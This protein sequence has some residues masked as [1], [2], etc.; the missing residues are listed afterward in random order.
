MNVSGA[1]Q[2]SLGLVS[3][4]LGLAALAYMLFVPNLSDST[5]AIGASGHHIQTIRYISL[6]QEGLGP[7][8]GALAFVIGALLIA[9]PVSS[10]LFVS[11]SKRRWGLVLLIVTGLLLVAA[12]LDT[13]GAL[14]WW[15]P[16]PLA[17]TPLTLSRAA[18]QLSRNPF[19]LLLLPSIVLAW[20]ATTGALRNR[21]ENA[22]PT[23]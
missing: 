8:Y 13:L 12:V 5:D 19:G 17:G 11:T 6:Y 14:T 18:S 23:V 20:F 3:S 4:V 7:M 10:L 2:V 22:R 1:R 21:S 15:T 16:L 9:I